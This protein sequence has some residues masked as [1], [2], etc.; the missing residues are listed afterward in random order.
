MKKFGLLIA[1]LILLTGCTDRDDDLSGVKIRVKNESS[2]NFDKVQ[3]GEAAML[4]TNIAPGNFSRYLEYKTAY[5]YA[6][7]NITVGDENYIL[8]PI[9]FVG[10][11]P[12]PEG[13]YTYGLK[14][15]EE[16]EVILNF[17]VD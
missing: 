15:S 17:M 10:E 13:F 8:Q 11:T 1:F 4:H 9:D 7:I 3:V 6:Y 5:N 16:G 12:L 2:F 14:I